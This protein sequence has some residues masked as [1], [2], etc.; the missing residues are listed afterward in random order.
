MALINVTATATTRQGFHLVTVDD[1]WAALKW[2]ATHNYTGNINV[3]TVGATPT[4]SLSFAPIPP[5]GSETVVIGDWIIIEN[6]TIATACTAANFPA[7]YSI[8]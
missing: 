4:Y 6:G 7:L 1:M 5:A 3:Y 8:V 2:F